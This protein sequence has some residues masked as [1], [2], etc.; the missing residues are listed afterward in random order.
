MART[1]TIDTFKCIVEIV[2]YFFNWFDLC[3]CERKLFVAVL[4]F[5]RVF[6]YLRVL[7][8]KTNIQWLHQSQRFLLCL[9]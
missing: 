3:V 7:P 4:L 2:R 5:F 8:F 1:I 6:F 9:P